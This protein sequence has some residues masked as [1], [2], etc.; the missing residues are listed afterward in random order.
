[1]IYFKA[2]PRC[3]GDVKPLGDQYGSYLSCLQCGYMLDAREKEHTSI[4]KRWRKEHMKA[5]S[6]T[7]QSTMQEAIG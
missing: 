2:C 1:M 6:L 7:S 4:V 5:M 3:R